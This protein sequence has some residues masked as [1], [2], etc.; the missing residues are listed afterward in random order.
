MP[1]GRCRLAGGLAAL[2]GHGERVVDR[3]CRRPRLACPGKAPVGGEL[4]LPEGRSSPQCRGFVRL[5]V[6]G[7][8]SM[9]ESG[10][11]VYTV[12][13]VP[14]GTLVVVDSAQWLPIGDWIGVE[15]GYEV[16]ATPPWAWGGSIAVET[17]NETTRF[18]LRGR[19]R[20]WLWGRLYAEALPGVFWQQRDLFSVPT[21]AS[22]TLAVS[23]WRPASASRG[24]PSPGLADLMHADR[25]L[26]PFG[27][28]SGIQD[29]DHLDPGGTWARSPS[30]EA[31]K[32]ARPF[33][34]P[35]R[36]SWWGSRLC[37]W[38]AHPLDDPSA[39]AEGAGAQGR[40]PASSSR[41]R[42]MPQIT[43]M[44]AAGRAAPPTD[45]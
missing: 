6:R 9:A 8:G 12:R 42:A 20:R 4:A 21:M 33:S 34:P 26:V 24:G 32:G 39:M 2:P 45:P 27:T 15:L 29:L 36:H 5:E 22:S 1:C 14:D 31:W 43:A 40:R 23:V 16:N 37:W 11:S 30:E 35:R 10:R 28:E 18:L 7:G 3:A 17:G 25:L 38:A 19:A 44:R 13:R 41:R